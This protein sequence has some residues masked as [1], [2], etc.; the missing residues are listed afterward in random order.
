MYFFVRHTVY[1]IIFDNIIIYNLIIDNIIIYIQINTAQIVVYSY[2]YLLDPK[3]AEIVSKE[4]GKETCVVFDEA[5]NIGEKLSANFIFEF[6][7]KIIIFLFQR[8][9]NFISFNRNLNKLSIKCQSYPKFYF[10]QQKF[11]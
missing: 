6:K 5:H 10:I 11:K 1:L 9:A 7:K 3:I 2:H 8:S 4:M